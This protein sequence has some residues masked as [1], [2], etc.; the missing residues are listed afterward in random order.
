MVYSQTYGNIFFIWEVLRALREEHY[1][2]Q[3]NNGE[4]SWAWDSSKMILMT[5]KYD[6]S[7]FFGA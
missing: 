5:T 4:Q 3:V 1:V 7:I 6:S 2:Y